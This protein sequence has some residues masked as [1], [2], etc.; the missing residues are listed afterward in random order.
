[1]LRDVEHVDAIASGGDLEHG[2]RDTLELGHLDAEADD[3]LLGEDAVG[4]ERVPQVHDLG[5][6]EQRGLVSVYRIFVK[7]KIMLLL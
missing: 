7:Y 5:A 2:G 1:M 3:L 6:V 4:G